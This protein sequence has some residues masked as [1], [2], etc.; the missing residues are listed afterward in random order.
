[1]AH[2]QHLA[3]VE[4]GIVATAFDQVRMQQRRREH[5]A[6]A[7]DALQ[8]RAARLAQQGGGLQQ[9]GQL[10]A[11]RVD[12]R[13]RCIGMRQKF[14]RGVAVA[15]AQGGQPVLP[16]TAAGGGFTQCHQR[17]GGAVHRRGDR[18]L[19]RGVIRQQQVGDVA[20]AASI[21]QGAAAEFVRAAKG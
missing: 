9:L 15:L 10:P 2:H 17:V 6:H 13:Q 14:A 19:S 5:F 4:Q 7:V 21:G 1:M 11:E 8:R 18:D 12:P 16:A 20:D 3:G